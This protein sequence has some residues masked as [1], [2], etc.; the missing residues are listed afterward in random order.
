MTETK[1]NPSLSFVYNLIKNT[2]GAVILNVCGKI[3][4]IKVFNVSFVNTILESI[5]PPGTYQTEIT[6]YDKFDE[7]VL[8]ITIVTTVIK[9]K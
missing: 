2:A 3:G 9:I 1:L 7:N 5:Y 6:G 8:N 4:E